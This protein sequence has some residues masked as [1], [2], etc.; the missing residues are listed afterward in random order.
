MKD[1]AS[2]GRTAG[3]IDAILAFR[4]ERAVSHFRALAEDGPELECPICGYRG[5]FSPV[6][7]KPSIWCPSCDSRP[8]HRLLKLW[9][10]REAALPAS[11]RVLH[12]A[13]EPWVEAALGPVAEYRTADLND[14]FELQLDLENLALPDGRFDLIIA[15]HVLE[16]LDDAKALREIARVLTPGG[17]AALT[18]P[19]VEGWSETLEGPDW[20]EDEARLYAT[21]HTHKR[22]YGKDFRE[23][24]R[25]AGLHAT[26]FTALE[27]DV[28]RYGLHRGEKI[29]L[30][31]KP[32]T[33]RAAPRASAGAT[34]HG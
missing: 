6:R 26:E 24:L 14:R 8:R 23:R 19:L 7:H 15:N 11:T 30:A 28:S 29:F 16:H 3:E 12:F 27:P 22:L 4:A 2:N 25:A 34:T 13:A 31:R 1:C 10:D 21:D 9:L 5:R 33:A 17:L 32:A 20:T 18:V